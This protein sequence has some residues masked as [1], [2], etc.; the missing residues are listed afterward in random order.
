MFDSDTDPSVHGRG[1]LAATPEH[2]VLLLLVSGHHRQGAHSVQ[3]ALD[4]AE[5]LRK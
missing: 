2:G 4:K 5:L 1:E 3:A